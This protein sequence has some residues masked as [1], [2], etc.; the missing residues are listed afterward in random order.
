MRFARS[1][2][3]SRG[4]FDKNDPELDSLSKDIMQEVHGDY[5]LASMIKKGVA[6]HIGYLPGLFTRNRHLETNQRENGMQ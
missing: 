4:I 3:E 6:Y 5:Y 1:F 2:A